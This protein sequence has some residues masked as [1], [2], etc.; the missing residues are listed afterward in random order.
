GA[1][2]N[3]QD[4]LM[5]SETRRLEVQAGSLDNRQGTLQAEGDNRLRI[6]GA[7]DIHGGRLDSGA[8]YLVLQ[9][10]SLDNGAGGVLNR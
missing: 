5:C 2:R 4:G 9:S 6:G 1:V 7:L 10:G 8:G 3:Q